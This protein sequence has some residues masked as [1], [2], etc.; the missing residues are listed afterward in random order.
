MLRIQKNDC[1]ARTLDTTAG[2]ILIRNQFRKV[3]RDN[4]QKMDHG[5]LMENTA[6]VGNNLFGLVPQA[7]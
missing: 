6:T 3:S 7:E 2:H 5:V 4:N 1:N